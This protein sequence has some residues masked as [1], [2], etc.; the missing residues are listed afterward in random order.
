MLKEAHQEVTAHQLARTEARREILLSVA[1]AGH[2]FPLDR[3]ST[4][5]GQEE[6]GAGLSDSALKGA[7]VCVGGD[8]HPKEAGDKPSSHFSAADCRWWVTGR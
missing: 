2:E 1:P 8:A 7:S 5:K 4:A 6:A 3:S